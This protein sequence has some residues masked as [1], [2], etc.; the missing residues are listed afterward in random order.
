[1]ADWTA[2]QAKQVLREGLFKGFGV[3]AVPGG[4]A[5]SLVGRL[6]VD[7]SGWLV[8]AHGQPII[9]ATA[10][11]AVSALMAIGFEVKRLGCSL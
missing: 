2:A 10:D 5:V 7:G 1:M 3:D 11:A 9:Y 8:D 6:D 4:W